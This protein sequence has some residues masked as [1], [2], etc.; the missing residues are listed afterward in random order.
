ML[1]SNAYAH[2]CM[3]RTLL[4]EPLPGVGVWE[5]VRTERQLTSVVSQ[6]LEE[7]GTTLR[8]ETITPITLHL[9]SDV[10]PTSGAWEDC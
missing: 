2:A 4:I 8:T 3:T 6:G 7:V 5:E 9:L 1:G 10:S